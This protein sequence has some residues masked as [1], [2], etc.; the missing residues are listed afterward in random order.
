MRILNGFLAFVFF[1]FAAVQVNDPDPLIWILIYMAMFTMAVMAMYGKYS[2]IAIVVLGV[3]YTLYSFYYL[4]GVLE[5]LQQEDKFKLFD[6]VAKMEHLYIEETREF[7]GLMI[8]MAV[9]VF[10]YFRSIKKD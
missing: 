6:N 5:W 7:L 2:R 10:Y 9:L 1:V 3:L 8:N 4:P